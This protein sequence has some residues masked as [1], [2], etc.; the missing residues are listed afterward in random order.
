MALQEAHNFSDWG[1]FE[2][3]EYP[4]KPWTDILPAAS[5]TAR[6]LVGK[7]VQYQSTWRLSASDV[8]DRSSY[9]LASL[10]R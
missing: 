8:S 7:L 9:H 6:D 4:A 5:V 2:F 10:S 1:K 3:K